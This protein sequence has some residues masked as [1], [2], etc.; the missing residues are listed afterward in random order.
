LSEDCGGILPERA[1]GAFNE[2]CPPSPAPAA[3]A[4]QR[5]FFAFLAGLFICRDAAEEARKEPFEIV[6]TSG[7]NDD[8]VRSEYGRPGPLWVRDNFLLT[9]IHLGKAE[10]PPLG[11]WFKLREK[12]QGNGDGETLPHLDGVYVVLRKMDDVLVA[13]FYDSGREEVWLAPIC[14]LPHPSYPAYAGTR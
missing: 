4:T 6:S 8:E 13:A 3:T 5:N 1:T 2:R 11:V 12:M 7:K 14:L 10:L 9:G